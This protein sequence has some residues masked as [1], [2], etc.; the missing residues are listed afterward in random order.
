MK[1]LKGIDPLNSLVKQ[2]A[3]INKT[4]HS[5]KTDEM[6]EKILEIDYLLS[7]YYDE[8]IGMYIPA[9]M[10]EANIRAGA[11]ARRNGKNAQIAIFVK[12]EMIPLNHDGPK[13]IEEL[14]KLEEFRD[15]RAVTINKNKVL[16]A[17]PRF[18]RWSLEFHLD[19]NEEF[20]NIDD[21]INAIEI[22]GSQKG[23]GDYRPR[24][25]RFTFSIKEA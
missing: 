3:A 20:M 16:R 12:E 1:S 4:H 21:L 18:N 7:A 14:Y 5:K 10:I 13:E 8:D 17:R 6:K 19:L 9:E 15:I 11:T 25:G 2:A 23:L 24:Y 22:G